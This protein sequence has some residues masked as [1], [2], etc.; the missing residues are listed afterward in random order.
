VNYG[1]DIFLD[2]TERELA[3][4]AE[5]K[6]Q[7]KPV[8]LPPG[9]RLCSWP[10]CRRP[11]MQKSAHDLCRKHSMLFHD[12]GLSVEKMNSLDY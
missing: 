8:E 5:I 3:K 4:I 2:L 10:S 1:A 6:A 12:L 9:A 7:R 11:V